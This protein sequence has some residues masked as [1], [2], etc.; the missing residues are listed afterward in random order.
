MLDGLMDP[1]YLDSNATTRPAP[2]VVRAMA[3]M[4][5][6]DWANPSSA[7]RLGQRARAKLDEA[8]EQVATLINCAPSELFFTG[9]GTEAIN[10]AIRGLLLA[11]Q[12]RRRIVTSQVEHSATREMCQ[13]LARDG[14][15]IVELG[16]N[17]QGE[18][19][20]MHFMDI[21]D[22]Q[23][24]LVT[25]MWANNETGVIWPVEGMAE[26]CRKQKVPIHVDA[27][28]AVGKIPVDVAKA[29]VDCA[30]FAAHKFHG[31]KGVGALY[32][33]K[34]VRLRPWLIGGPQERGR[35]G[36]TENTA[37]IVGMGAAAKVASD[38]LAQMPRVK[39]LRDGFES[40]LLSTIPQTAINGGL[41][42]RLPNTSNV[43]F[44]AL[45]AEA[46]LLSLSEKGVCASA[47]AACSS[48]SLEPSH[49]LKAM[50]VNHRYAHGAIRFSLS[51]YT[52]QEEV[53]H[54]L[55]VLG[56]IIQKLRSVMPV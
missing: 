2:E 18:I 39:Q 52:T 42:A 41:T 16:V 30:S 14:Y 44:A 6:H 33:R 35:R 34:G 17:D 7:H 29:Q 46:I 9:C 19:D 51:R 45:S 20:L 24:A 27:T 11:R 26:Y 47:G 53:D 15:E 36:G 21:V 5:E 8:R 22:D 3:D 49:V 10:T 50:N 12:P 43:G 31:P 25:L 4:L 56:P 55:A 13:Q 28:Q 32:T 54:T 48:G 40:R 23:C 37:G 38:S 1:I